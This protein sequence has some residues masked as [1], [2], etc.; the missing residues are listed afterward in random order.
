M[1]LANP[2]DNAPSIVYCPRILIAD[3]RQ[4]RCSVL[5]YTH[6]SL[7][8]TLCAASIVKMLT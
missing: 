7:A 2:I 5:T 4:P 1:V 6:Y 3:H 8:C